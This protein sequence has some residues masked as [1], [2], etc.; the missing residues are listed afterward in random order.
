M[1]LEKISK[2]YYKVDIMKEVIFYKYYLI[3]F[4]QDEKKI[5]II[6]NRRYH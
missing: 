4:G 6:Q 1:I 3:Q 2:G 5:Q